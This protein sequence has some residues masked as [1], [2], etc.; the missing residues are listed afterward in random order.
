MESSMK[1]IKLTI[2][3]DG[4]SYHGWQSQTNA[5]AIQD[6]LS[7]AIRTVTGEDCSL[8]GS[9]RTDAGVHAL[10]QA[11]NFHTESGIPPDRFSYALNSVLP[12]DIVI[13]DSK[14]VGPDFHS[15][16]STTGK[17]YCYLIYNSTQPSALL[18]NRAWHI[19]GSLDLKKM[20]K[21]ADYFIGTFDFSAFM[22]SNSSVKT[23][24]RTINGIY[25]DKL[26]ENIIKLEVWGNG[27]LYNMV[28]IITGTLAEVGK[29][30]REPE[31]IPGIIESKDRRMAGKTAPAH[32][33]YLMEVYY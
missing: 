6:I 25:L 24:I 18:K 9:S 28:R 27:F 32:G 23:T 14:E 15:R 31:C 22:A 29:G 20:Q 12:E 21:A 33:L 4:T 2:E 26:G 17:K 1:N 5:S 13:R 11:A 7:N 3:Y 19:S 8:T 30:K 16:Y 10:G